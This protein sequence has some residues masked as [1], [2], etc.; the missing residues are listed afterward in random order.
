MLLLVS[1]NVMGIFFYDQET[2]RQCTGRPSLFQNWQNFEWA[3]QKWRQGLSFS[4]ISSC[5]RDWRGTWGLDSILRTL[6]RNPIQAD[7]KSWEKKDICGGKPHGFC[8][9]TSRY[10]PIFCLW[11]NFQRTGIFLCY[12]RTYSVFILILVA[13]VCSQKL[14]WLWKNTFSFC[15]RGQSKN[16]WVVEKGEKWW[17]TP[18]LW[19]MEG[20]STSVYS[21]RRGVC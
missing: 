1:W 11:S 4:P 5:Y 20:K 12:A 8:T 6:S 17:A 18:L 9:R 10:S 2:I 15:R 16:I 13:C 21:Y 19:R 7:E 14:K 3:S